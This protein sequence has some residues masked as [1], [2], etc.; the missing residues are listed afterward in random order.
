MASQPCWHPLR[1]LEKGHQDLKTAIRTAAYQALVRPKV[2]NASTLWN[3]FA[4]TY[5][6]KIEMFQRRAVRRVNSNYSSYASVSSILN[7]GQKSKCLID[8]LL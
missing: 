2:E 7:W 8:P 3:P 5:I 4:Q 1:F 6:N